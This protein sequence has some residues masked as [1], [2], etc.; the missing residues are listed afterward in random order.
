M[1]KSSWVAFVLISLGLGALVA[2]SAAGIL[3][4]VQR[5]AWGVGGAGVALIFMGFAV[6]GLGAAKIKRH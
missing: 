1:E 4:G 6:A 5:W 2:S 3:D